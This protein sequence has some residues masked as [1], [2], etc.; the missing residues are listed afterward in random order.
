MLAI[1][2]EAK[3]IKGSVNQRYKQLLLEKSLSHGLRVPCVHLYYLYHTR[4]QSS[5]Q[6]SIF[7]TGLEQWG[8]CLVHLCF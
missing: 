5:V 7:L 1:N 3:K 4:M 2:Y 6:F 8:L